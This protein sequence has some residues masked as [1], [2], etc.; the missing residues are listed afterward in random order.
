MY[1]FLVVVMS[2]LMVLL[3]LELDSNIFTF[4]I[5]AKYNLRKVHVAGFWF[6]F[7]FF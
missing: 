7:F 5:N 4:V 3:L 1:S 2:Y 6:G